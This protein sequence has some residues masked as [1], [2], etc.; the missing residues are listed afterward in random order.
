MIKQQLGIAVVGSG[1]I[2]TLRARFAAEHPAVNF[3]AVSDLDEGNAS[4]LAK[5]VGAQFFSAHNREIIARPEVNAVIVSTSEG[6]HLEPVLQAIE[7]GK[8]VLVE[9]PIGLNVADADCI[10]AAASKAGVEV[11]VGYSRRY[12]HRYLLA[13]E[14]VVQGR[15]GKI[16][17]AAARVYNSRSQALGQLSRNPGATPIVDS[18]T[19]Y[20][21]LMNWM[22]EGTAPVDVF[23]CG[24]KGVL[25]AAGYDVDDVNWAILTY[26]DGTV[27]NLGVSYALPAKYP[28]LGH[29]ARFELLGTEG[30]I[31]LD[32]D[33]TDQLMYSEKGVPHVYLP[34]HNVNMVFLGS[35]APGDWALGDL[36]GPTACE[37]R[38]WLDHLSTGKRCVIATPK[39]ARITLETTLAIALSTNSGKRVKLP[40]SE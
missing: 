17:G 29:S 14:Q 13:K 7:L 6:E 21:D 31:I 10:I 8:P 37:T 34:N 5:Q 2:G 1:R 32:D 20:V 25:K 27:V 15:I 35:G 16:V 38:A 12:Y 36:W 23:A 30:V 22:L 19:Y 3:L 4:K 33:H 28:A 39:E 26:A 18:L 24:Q 11:R 9:K 40:L